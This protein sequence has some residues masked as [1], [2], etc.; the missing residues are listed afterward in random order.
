MRLRRFNGKFQRC[1]GKLEPCDC[2]CI[3]AHCWGEHWKS[4]FVEYLKQ[5]LPT[6]EDAAFLRVTFDFPAFSD[7]K[8][9][10]HSS[11][12]GSGGDDLSFDIDVTIATLGTTPIVARSGPNGYLP[13][14]QPVLQTTTGCSVIAQA[15]R[16]F[17]DYGTDSEIEGGT[18]AE[19]RCSAQDAFVPYEVEITLSNF[20]APGFGEF[21]LLSQ[22][23]YQNSSTALCTATTHIPSTVSMR[24][25]N[26]TSILVKYRTRPNSSFPWTE[27]YYHAVFETDLWWEGS[28]AINASTGSGQTIA[29]ENS[30]N[31]VL[32]L[33]GP[34]LDSTAFATPDD[35]DVT[36][37]AV[38]SDPLLLNLPKCIELTNAEDDSEDTAIR[39][40]EATICRDAEF[41]VPHYGGATVVRYRGDTLWQG[42]SW[43]TVVDDLFDAAVMPTSPP[44]LSGAADS[45]GAT[46]FPTLNGVPIISLAPTDCSNCSDCPGTITLTRKY[47]TFTASNT[48]AAEDFPGEDDPNWNVED[49][50]D[51][52]VYEPAMT[53]SFAFGPTP[54]AGS[55]YIGIQHPSDTGG[56]PWSG[57]RRFR[58]TF[59]VTV[60]GDIIFLIVADN[61]I[62]EILVNGV[63]IPFNP[64][65]DFGNFYPVLIPAGVLTTGTNTIEIQVI[66]GGGAA[67]MLVEWVL[68]APTDYTVPIDIEQDGDACVWEN[69]TTVMDQFEG[70]WRLRLTIDGTEHVRYAAIGCSACP[71]ADF[72]GAALS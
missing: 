69:G 59:N 29:V 1:N 71:P 27:S 22:T 44:F 45:L 20:D 41:P 2:G 25:R 37:D 47:A 50:N 12:S 68:T 62:G 46:T 6:G 9:F 21:E 10:S 36:F 58:S 23:L 64:A 42:G 7:S 8:S 17:R 57:A 52:G 13:G 72:L 5:P 60:L 28:A 15:S 51:S 4:A 38:P 67:A 19:L 55:G 70:R 49:A 31:Q 16:I 3:P 35:V 33:Q 14:S 24:F 53:N 32:H 40:C 65:I 11:P 63:P 39:E 43:P 66:D 48:N 61:S 30:F 26:K 54:S 34:A 18:A 56:V